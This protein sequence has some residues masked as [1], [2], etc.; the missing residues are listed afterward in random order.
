[1]ISIYCNHLIL[2]AINICDFPSPTISVCHIFAKSILCIVVSLSKDI[3]AVIH[4][5]VYLV[6]RTLKI[7]STQSVLCV[8]SI[9]TMTACR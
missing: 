9:L 4:F 5:R 7:N 8:Y 1:M 3:F 6:P 2:G